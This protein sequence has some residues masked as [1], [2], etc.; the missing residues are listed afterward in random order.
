MKRDFSP[1]VQQLNC[2]KMNSQLI[3]EISRS[4]KYAL[5][6]NRHAPL[7]TDVK[8][9]IR[10]LILSFVGHPNAVRSL[11]MT[12]IRDSLSFLW[13]RK[14]LVTF[15]PTDDLAWEVDQCLLDLMTSPLYQPLELL[16]E[17]Q[18]ELN[19]LLHDRSPEQI[20]YLLPN[21]LLLSTSDLFILSKA[22]GHVT[23]FVATETTEAL[24]A[25]YH[26][27]NNLDMLLH[28]HLLYLHPIELK[29]EKQATVTVSQ[30]IGI[31]LSEALHENN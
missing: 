6:S 21:L 27:T 13:W 4:C 18:I 25:Y 31:L 8:H 19:D 3:K 22:I 23:N 29:L 14:Y 15:F 9:F 2:M 1:I 28:Y 10:D 20:D 12:N 24:M 26:Y 17:E 11:I 16:E 7:P 30:Q 5:Y